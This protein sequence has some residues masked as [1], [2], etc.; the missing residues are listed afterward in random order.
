MPG[1]ARPRAAPKGVARGQ[2]QG[3]LSSPGEQGLHTILEWH[4]PA[5]LFRL[6]G[7]QQRQLARRAH[8][9]VRLFQRGARGVGQ[10]LCPILAYADDR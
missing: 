1:D 7:W 3:G 2:H 5:L 10:A 9:D 8:D 6:K 4:W